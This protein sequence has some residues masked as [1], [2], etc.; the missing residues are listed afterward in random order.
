M[1]LAIDIT[2]GYSLS[3]KVHHELLLK[4]SSIFIHFTVEAVYNN[5]LYITH[6][7][8][9]FSFESGCSMQGLKLIKEDWPIVLK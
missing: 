9:H 2:D 7:S 8:E 4:D 5:Q 1:A 3:N 6:K